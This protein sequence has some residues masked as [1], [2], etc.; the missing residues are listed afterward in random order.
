MRFG[1]HSVKYTL[2]ALLIVPSLMFAA[3][4]R[5]TTCSQ[6]DWNEHFATINGHVR[7]NWHPPIEYRPISCTI[8]LRLDFRSEVAHVEILSCDDD[9]A[10][11]KSAEDAGYVS[12]PLPK[13]RNRACFSKQMTVRLKFTPQQEQGSYNQS[14]RNNI[15]KSTAATF[16]VS[17]PVE[18]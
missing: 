5:S 3:D 2:Y 17:A 15:D 14:I 9:E 6:T 12:S 8:L 10:I 13:P 7:S 4:D 18:M 1:M 16:L 11:R